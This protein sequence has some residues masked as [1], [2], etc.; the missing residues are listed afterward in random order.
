[1]RTRWDNRKI[2]TVPQMFRQNCWTSLLGTELKTGD[3]LAAFLFNIFLRCS[4]YVI[5][6]KLVETICLKMW[7]HCPGV[8]NVQFHFPSAVQKRRLHK[9]SNTNGKNNKQ[10]HNSSQIFLLLLRLL[11]SAHFLSLIDAMSPFDFD[12]LLHFIF[13]ISQG[14]ARGLRNTWVPWLDLDWFRK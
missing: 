10:K 13:W 11:L 9:L 14:L 7:D 3:V 4:I 1:M 12:G 2:V 6:F 5:N 8:R